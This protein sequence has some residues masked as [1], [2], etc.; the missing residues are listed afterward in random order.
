M[1]VLPVYAPRS[2][3]V[4]PSVSTV[5]MSKKDKRYKLAKRGQN[6]DELLLTVAEQF[7]RREGQAQISWYPGHIA[8]AEKRLQEVLSAVDVVVEVRDARIPIS[9]THPIVD[10]W[11]QNRNTKRVV[12]ISKID[13]APRSAMS[14][15]KAYLEN[16]LEIPVAFMNC[17]E[18]GKGL[19]DLKKII[20]KIGKD[21]NARRE[22]RE[23]R[24]R[25]V[26]VA[27]IGYPNV[28][29]SA[30]LN[31]LAGKV[32]AKSENKAGVTKSLQWSR[33]DG[34]DLLDSPGI[35]PAKLLTQEIAVH[36][37]ICDD[38][39]SASYDTILVAAALIDEV[40]K[41]GFSLP[42][43]VDHS[44]FYKRYQLNIGTMSGEEYIFRLAQSKFMGLEL[45]AAERILD[46]WR[47]GRLGKMALEP[48]PA[49]PY[50]TG[51]YRALGLKKGCD[52]RQIKIGYR[53]KARVLHPDVG[54]NPD[55]WD[56]VNKA[57]T[58]L[59]DEGGARKRYDAHGLIWDIQIGNYRVLNDGEQ[60]P[61]IRSVANSMGT[62]LLTAGGSWKSVA[63]VR[64]GQL[65]M[66]LMSAGVAR[67]SLLTKAPP[68]RPDMRR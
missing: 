58:I 53:D 47:K 23:M 64:K 52:A 45:Q 12:C 19:I 35:I 2:R 38:I 5:M 9:T 61:T 39:G 43:Y 17:K 62:K 25:N 29:K 31:R 49:I 68:K 26:R 20:N 32:K 11:L 41:V 54:G 13:M 30:L 36:L 7:R 42:S 33:V 44:G 65:R 57:Y 16:S 6:E 48:P 10:S 3:A 40:R 22:S 59:S 18:G 15:W 51:Y 4:S 37:A 1:P 60:P 27:V 66:P 34:F 46:D 67:S 8:K 56:K 24:P 14:M 63:K 50:H 21:I 28:G 55:D